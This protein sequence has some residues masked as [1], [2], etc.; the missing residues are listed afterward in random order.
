VKPPWRI[1]ALNPS[2]PGWIRKFIAEHWG[3][4]EMVAHG[5]VTKPAKLPGFACMLHNDVIGLVT[6]KITDA[7]CEIISLDSLRPQN[8]IGTALI[9]AV[10]QAAGEMKCTKLWLVTTNDNL[11]ALGFYQ[12][13]GFKI[14]AIHPNAVDEAR[15]LKPSIPL[16]GLEGIPLTDEIVLEM[17]LADVGPLR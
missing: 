16:I 12:R 11:L 13:R 5:E 2:D 7:E 14:T 1:R 15:K 4:E 6:Y 8:G 10:K 3:A 9:E 17:N